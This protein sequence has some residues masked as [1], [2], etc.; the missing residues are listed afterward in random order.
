VDQFPDAAP[1]FISEHAPSAVWPVLEIARG[2]ELRVVDT[3]GAS[4]AALPAGAW[5]SAVGKAVLAPITVHGQD[6]VGAVLV[7]GVS[8]HRPLDETYLSFF[9]LLSDQLVGSISAAVSYEAERKRVQAL[10]EIDRAKTTF[11]SNIS[12]EFRT[13]LTLMLGPLE[14]AIDDEALPA[15]ARAQLQVVQRNG[16]RLLKLVN[17]LL[18]FS[19]IEAGKAVASFEPVDLGALT[20]D[21]AGLF[22]SAVERAGM[23]LEVDCGALDGEVWVDRTMWEKIVLNLLSNAFKFTFEGKIAV[24]IAGQDGQAVLTVSDSGVG[25]AEAD[26]PKMFER[27]QRVEGSRSRSHEGSGIGLALVRDLAG[28]HGGQAAIASTLGQ[29]TTV[30]VS[31]PLGN[32]HLPQEHLAARSAPDAHDQLADAYMAE[33]ELWL[34]AGRA[35]EPAASAGAAHGLLYVVDDNPDMRDYVASLL[36]ATYRVRTFANGLLALEAARAVRPDLIVSDVMMPV[37]GGYELLAALKA[38]KPLA[39]IPVLLLS[40]RAGEEARISAMRAG[41]DAYLE[42]PFSRR[43]LVAKVDALLL[44]SRVHDIETAHASRMRLILEQAPAA[45]A[46]LR[47]PDHVF[48]LANP[49]YL[50]LVGR[51]GILHKPV[52]EALPELAGQ[53]IYELLDQVYRT[54]EPYVGR[55]LR[56]DIMTGEPPQMQECY[57][58]FVYQPTFDEAG[59]VDGI[60]IVVFEVSEVVRARRAAEAGSRAKDEFMA[61]LGHELR[62]PLAPIMTALEVMRLRGV[63]GLQKEHGIIERQARHLVGLVNDLLDVARVAEGKVELHPVPVELADVAAAALETAGPLIGERRHSLQVDIPARGL[64]LMADEQR[65]SQVFSN[66]LTNAAKYS[67]PG[68]LIVVRGRRDGADIVLSVADS[69]NGIDAEMLPRIFELFYQH[70]QSLARS[71]G[72]LGLG[73]SIVRSIVELHGGSVTAHSEGIGKGSTFTV[74]VPAALDDA[75]AQ[76]TG[77]GDGTAAQDA[78]P[79]RTSILVVDDNADAAEMLKEWLQSLGYAVETALEAA[80]ALRKLADWAPDV[81]ILDIGLP[82]MNGYELA[83]RIRQMGSGRAIKLIALTGYGQDSD[84]ERAMEAGFDRHLKKPVNPAYLLEVIGELRAQT[85]SS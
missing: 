66:L 18:D 76:G 40:A 62:N 61:M 82:G 79:P 27:F 56:I 73:L 13:P 24:R 5:G 50:S 83:A 59:Q 2:G 9:K 49:R 71:R 31:V 22:R 45:I 14:E 16:T 28:L 64:Q 15:G 43:E 81:A 72:G 55:A 84:R 8:P 68:S 21:L 29:G 3:L 32:A 36:S 39:D 33:A 69:G 6:S 20:A 42:K 7:A 12:H 74:R 78:A 67:E 35:G 38:E 47:G 60:A 25:I 41:T 44:R 23:A 34:S 70:P 1:A 48:E 58:D 65:M 30:T 77:Q 26:L 51:R 53:G 46:L 4:G 10:A 52:R 63:Q 37:M 17:A 80:A 54:A 19:R 75:A 85:C 57:F 11:F